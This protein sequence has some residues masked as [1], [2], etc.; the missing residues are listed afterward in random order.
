VSETTSCAEESVFVQVT[1][2]ACVMVVGFGTNADVPN[3]IAP[4]GMVIVVVEPDGAG[5]G[6]GEG[7]GV[8]DGDGVGE[9]AEGEVFDE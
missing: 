5:D 1:T 6:V 7:D 9:G 8:G 3:V 4:A 2:P